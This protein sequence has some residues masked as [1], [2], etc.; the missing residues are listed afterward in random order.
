MEKEDIFSSLHPSLRYVLASWMRWEDLRDIQLQTIQAF[1][2]G[3][4]LLII[5]PTAGG[6]SEAAF[7]PVLD[8]IIKN[9][10]LL[11]VC[12]YVAPLKALINDI[13][14]RLQNI[15]HPLQFDLLVC[16]GDTPLDKKSETPVILMTTPETLTVLLY[17]KNVS[18]LSS[19]R[20]CIIDELHTLAGTTRGSQILTALNRIE[21]ENRNRIT[22]IGLSATIG[23]PGDVLE[24]MRGSHEGLVV[25]GEKSS[26]NNTFHLLSSEKTDIP[27]ILSRELSGKRSLVFSGSRKE[28]EVLASTLKNGIPDVF[29]HHSSLSSGIRK[30]TEEKT[31]Q[32]IPFTVLCTSTL[33][34]GIDIGDLD[35]VV[36]TGSATSVAS[37][38]QRLGRAGRRGGEPLMYLFSTSPEET[39]HNLAALCCAKSGRVEP[40]IPPRYP[41]DLLVRELLLLVMT[42]YRVSYSV[43]K[44]LSSRKPYNSIPENRLQEILSHL[45]FCDWISCDGDLYIPGGKMEQIRRNPGFL[46]SLIGDLPSNR[47]ISR[48]GEEIGS[49]P[50]SSVPLHCFVLGGTAWE[51]TGQEEGD[52]LVV[53]PSGCSAS[54]PTWQG[55]PAEVTPLILSKVRSLVAGV[56]VPFPVSDKIRDEI[57]IFREQFP[58]DLPDKSISI[59]IIGNKTVFYTFLGKTWNRVIGIFVEKKYEFRYIHS[60]LY[61][62]TFSGILS[63]TTITQIIQYLQD[64]SWEDIAE[65]IPG[66]K[67]SGDRRLSLLPESCIWEQWC[68]DSLHIPSL[69]ETIRG[70]DIR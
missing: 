44:K 37:F 52:S 60:D 17:K 66:P 42:R 14:E 2:T 61:S 3:S 21:E 24:W 47:I 10:Y 9:G 67:K 59:R 12:L 41:Y 25:T 65:Y 6:K 38:L 34:L 68:S 55:T 53:S 11:P 36:Q 29:V 51:A 50:V 35:L 70:L 57:N 64:C 63:S 40:V 4:D 45:I 5:S 26:K 8:N 13:A 28:T 56:P 30:K 46:Y 43:F 18:L 32:G 16:H 23:N 62:I 19:V 31:T 54:P 27:L 58:P 20:Y 69:L 15:L 48:D 22:R 33:E 49:V 1:R 39:C 7:I